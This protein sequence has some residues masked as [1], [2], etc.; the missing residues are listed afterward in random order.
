MKPIR[1]YNL[2]AYETFMRIAEV[3]P[4]Q[5]RDEVQGRLRVQLMQNVSNIIYRQVYWSKG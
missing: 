3:I 2:T 1:D 4:V 5:L